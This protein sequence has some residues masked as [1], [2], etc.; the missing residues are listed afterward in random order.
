MHTFLRD[1]NI[2]TDPMH[3]AL[4]GIPTA[5]TAFFIHSARLARF[6]SYLKGE[7]QRVSKH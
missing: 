4:W 1:L 7:Q 5:V 6:D 3:I 2:E